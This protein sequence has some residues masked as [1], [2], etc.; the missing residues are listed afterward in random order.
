MKTLIITSLLIIS[1]GDLNIDAKG[2]KEELTQQD[3]TEKDDEKLKL[4]EN[5][6]NETNVTVE[7]NVSI[8]SKEAKEKTKIAPKWYFT[9]KNMN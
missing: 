3:N 4:D 7:T 2:K 9:N 5:E 1:C 8:C 6:K